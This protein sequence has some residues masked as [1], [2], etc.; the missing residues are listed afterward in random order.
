MFCHNCGLKVSSDAKFCSNCGANLREEDIHKNDNEIIEGRGM[1]RNRKKSGVILPL[2]IP[3]LAFSLLVGGLGWFYFHETKVN[4]KVIALKDSAEELALEGKYEQSKSKL[5]SAI[6]LRPRYYVLQNNLEVVMIAEELQAEMQDTNALIKDKKFEDAEKELSR[7]NEKIAK[8]NGPLFQPIKKELAEKDT[9]IKVGKINSELDQLKTVDELARKLAVLSAIPSEEGKAVKEQI[10]NR[11]VQITTTN[12]E[13]ELEQK[14]FTKAISLTDKG[15]QYAI[16]DKRLLSLK[17]KI[18]QTRTEFEL[19]EQERIEKAMEAAA[20]EDLK[21]RNA[22]LEVVGLKYVEDDAG[23]MTI[24]GEV[25]NIVSKTVSSITVYYNILSKD[26]TV[27][28][29]GFTTVYPYKLPPGEKAKFED[30]YYG[31]F[32]DVTVEIEN[33]TW[34]VEE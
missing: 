22:A 21:N 7:L 9:M 3:V 2:L 29:T 1:D 30:Y 12:A 24:T 14:Q 10:L 17:E 6:D 11:I 5:S 13:T 8:L 15:L 33:M 31:V 25:K 19:A 32:E 16:N 28:D 23:G 4:G 27:L 18:E 34:L 20:K 26:K